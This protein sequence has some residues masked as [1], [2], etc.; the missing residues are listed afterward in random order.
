MSNYFKNILIAVI[1]SPRFRSMARA[2]NVSVYF[3]KPIPVKVGP[4]TL[5]AKTID[6]LLALFL[7]KF[8]F[9]SSFEKEIF[10]SL[11]KPGMRVVDI[12][13]NLGY[14]TLIAARI[15]GP[16]GRVYAFE[17]EEG[18]FSLLA[19]AVEKSGRH[20]IKLFRKAIAEKSGEGTLF[21]SEEHRGDHRTF[22]NGENRRRII[23]ETASLDE[24]MAH[25]GK[26]DIV[27]IDIEGAESKALEGMKKILADNEGIKIMSEFWPRGISEA[28]AQP[29]D[30]LKR[31]KELGFEI[32][33]INGRDRCLQNFSPED[34]VGSFKPQEYGNIIL[35]RQGHK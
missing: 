2:I 5:Y 15:V 26:I 28:G 20:N 33:F 13:A 25:E 3:H 30:F 35:I 18:N 8:G 10:E 29:L 9:R 4:F 31:W 23:V 17:P 16:E 1:H 7:L 14:Y 34:L 12:G 27:K 21:F 32:L 22:D 19:L 24:I 6:R 11:L